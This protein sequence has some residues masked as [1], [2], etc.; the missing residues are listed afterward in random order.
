MLLL[1]GEVVT[2]SGG[3]RVGPPVPSGNEQ[4]N[5]NENRVRRKEKRYL[6]VR[7]TQHPGDSRR[8]VIASTSGQNPDY[9]AEREPRLLIR[10][11]ASVEFQFAIRLYL[12]HC[13]HH[14]SHSIGPKLRETV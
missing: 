6:A 3:Q 10:L 7:K 4:Q 2:A 12:V 1:R 5:G 8:Q 9:R 13:L 11:G 14:S